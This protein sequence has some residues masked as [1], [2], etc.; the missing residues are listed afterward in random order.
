ME[1]NA[2]RIT[3]DDM[4]NT[5]A[6]VLSEIR[7]LKEEIR[8]MT[9]HE[10][11]VVRVPVGIDRASEIT[12]KA[13]STLYRYTAKGLIP[14]YKKGKTMLFYEDELMAWVSN[15][16]CETF[17]DRVAMARNG[18]VQLTPSRH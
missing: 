16:R 6:L 18:I 14:C 2:Q 5:M 9:K 3:F 1:E 4:P 11:P 8:E 12:G 7:S 17:E 10:K 13:V 15:G